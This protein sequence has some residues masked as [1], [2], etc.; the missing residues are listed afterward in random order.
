MRA[1]CRT[2]PRPSP[3]CWPATG[4]TPARRHMLTWPPEPPGPRGS[5]TA[6]PVSS[7]AARSQHQQASSGGCNAGN[8]GSG[9]WVPGRQA[10]RGGSGRA[11]PSPTVPGG[12]AP[13]ARRPA[14]PQHV[15]SASERRPGLGSRQGP[16]RSCPL[17]I[18]RGARRPTS[19][20]AASTKEPARATRRPAQGRPSNALPPKRP[21]KKA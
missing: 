17:R 15:P 5:S 8:H 11:A 9:C 2:R 4:A 12:S 20:L 18:H 16:L 3:G 19:T 13:G 6:T 7:K 1:R 10:R 21:R 14:V